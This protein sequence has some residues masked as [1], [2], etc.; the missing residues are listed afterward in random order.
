MRDQVF[1]FAFT[2]VRAA[3]LGIQKDFGVGETLQALLLL[4]RLVM[5]DSASHRW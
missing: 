2:K 3:G 1:I 4:S 5:S